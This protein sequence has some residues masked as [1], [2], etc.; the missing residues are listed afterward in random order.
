[1]ISHEPFVNNLRDSGLLS[2][3]EIR[4]LTEALAELDEPATDVADRLVEAGLLT[5]YQAEAVRERRFGALAVG[6]YLVLGK[7]GAGGMGTVYKA[8]HRRMKRLVALKLLASGVD[9][10]GTFLRRFQRE[11]E[12][13]SR[14]CHANIVM[15]F[16]AG[17]SDLGHY[18]VM[19]Y[20]DGCDL[21][22]EVRERGPLPVR[23]AVACTLQAARAL[24]HAHREGVIHRDVKPANLLRAASGVVKVAD[25]GLARLALPDEAEDADG[26][27]CAGGILGTVDYMP[28]EQAVDSHQIDHRADVYSLGC[29]LYYL[30]VGRPPY[31]GDRVM[32][33]LRKHREAPAP[34]PAESR[35][36]VPAA[37]DALV[38]RMAAK[39]PDERPQ[40][41]SQVVEILEALLAVLPSHGPCGRRGAW[42]PAGTTAADV[43]SSPT[44]DATP[45]ASAES[46]NVAFEIG[47]VRRAAF[48]C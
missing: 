41:M 4:S 14:L 11:I 19:E 29:T 27:T 12:A 36:D 28:P 5:A 6:P 45:E 3:E 42:S 48:A 47:Q 16:D 38:R 21:A 1:M 33:V 15:A 34:A 23:E 17:E 43:P 37:L 24:D 25:F 8:R 10:S 31:S 32:A 30:L 22:S 13:V 18:L 39:D 20:V 44:I 46:Q 40:A 7:L 2:A 35:P 9:P 26:L